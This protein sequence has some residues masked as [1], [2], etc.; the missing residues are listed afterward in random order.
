MRPTNWTNDTRRDEDNNRKMM[1][2]ASRNGGCQ[3]A[4]LADTRRSETH[5]SRHLEP[6]PDKSL[7]HSRANKT[8]SPACRACQ[9]CVPVTVRSSLHISASTRLP[10]IKMH[11]WVHRFCVRTFMCVM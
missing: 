10:H 8:T 7:F 11:A 9:A 4:R 6:G 1:A 3:T 5:D 2:A